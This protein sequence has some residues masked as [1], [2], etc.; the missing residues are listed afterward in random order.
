MAIVPPFLSRSANGVLISIS[1]KKHK[2]A[3]E[4]A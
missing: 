2:R 1:G 4:I 3:K